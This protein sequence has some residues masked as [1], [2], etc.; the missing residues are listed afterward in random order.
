VG[1]SFAWCQWELRRG[2]S[3]LYLGA[4]G[5]Y[6]L[7]S[8]NSSLTGKTYLNGIEGSPREKLPSG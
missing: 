8:Y 4:D 5:I 3:V 1:D 2:G 7:G 6:E